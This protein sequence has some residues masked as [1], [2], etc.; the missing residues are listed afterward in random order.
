MSSI[1]VFTH[2]LKK[3]EHKP[4]TFD[5]TDLPIIE[6]TRYS[7]EYTQDR[8]E[9]IEAAGKSNHFY[10]VLKI[11]TH[12]FD[13]GRKLNY[14][15]VRVAD[16]SSGEEFDACAVSTSTSPGFVQDGFI[17]GDFCFE[18]FNENEN[19]S[20]YQASARYLLPGVAWQA[21]KQ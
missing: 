12:E 20:A 8:R 4:F 1:G 9:Y 15:H 13:A 21:A 2:G 11:K 14:H 5:I 17:L 7:L 10:L 3:H 18:N 16:L 6:Q 19:E